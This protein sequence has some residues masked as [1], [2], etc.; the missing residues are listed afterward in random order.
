MILVKS[1]IVIFLLL[2]FFRYFDRFVTYMSNKFDGREGF[3]SEADTSAYGAAD[4]SAYGAADTSAYGAADTSGA[5][6][7]EV[8]ED[9]EEE[10]SYNVGGGNQT[11]MA[12][13]AKLMGDLQDKMKELL[14]LSDKATV[15]NNDIKK[16]K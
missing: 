6:T 9:D 5:D 8:A 11:L 3:A 2:F 1:L 14:Q 16:I 12:E 7:S 13:D 4:T 10:I 15:I